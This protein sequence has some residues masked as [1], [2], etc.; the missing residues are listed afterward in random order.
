MSWKTKYSLLDFDKEKNYV[1]AKFVFK[2]RRQMRLPWGPQTSKQVSTLRR[3]VGSSG[4]KE[5]VLKVNMEDSITKAIKSAV[6]EKEKGMGVSLKTT[7]W[8]LPD[9]LDTLM[10]ISAEG[11]A[12]EEFKF[13]QALL[14]WSQETYFF[15]YPLCF[16]FVSLQFTA[17]IRQLN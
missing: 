10:V 17:R 16:Y 13:D 9:R 15:F 1:T 2:Q 8:L 14:K 3:H 4:H 12:K 7:N 6:Q 11:P 5:A